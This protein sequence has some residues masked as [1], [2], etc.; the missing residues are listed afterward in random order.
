MLRRADTWG[1]AN[2]LGK[3][4]IVLERQTSG[5][6]ADWW[7]RGRLDGKELFDF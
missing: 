5:E 7:W 1:R 6:R 3:D 2:L 4:S